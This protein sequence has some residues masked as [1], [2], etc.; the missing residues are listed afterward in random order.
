QHCHQPDG[1]GTRKLLR[2]QERRA[3]RTPRFR[4]KKKQ[5]RG[6]TPP[7]AFPAAPRRGDHAGHPAHPLHTPPPAPPPR[8]ALVDNNSLSPQP[9]EFNTGRIEQEVQQS[10]GLQPEDNSQMGQSS[11]WQQIYSRAIQGRFIPVPYHDVKISDPSKLASLSEAY[12]QVT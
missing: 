3:P 7:S 9:N 6:E 10:S 1:P 4:N 5:P 2:M 11:T 12:R 8:Q